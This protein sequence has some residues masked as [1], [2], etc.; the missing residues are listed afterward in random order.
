MNNYIFSLK[1]KKTFFLN[2]LAILIIIEKRRFAK[3]ILVKTNLKIRFEC[4]F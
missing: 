3:N 4:L 1:L 2:I